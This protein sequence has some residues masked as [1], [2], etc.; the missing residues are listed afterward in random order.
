MSRTFP[1]VPALMILAAC[2]NGDM[3]DLEGYVREIKARAP[4]PLEPLPEIAPIASLPFP[5]QSRRDPFVPD[6]QS[7][8]PAP[9]PAGD[10]R[11]PDPLRHKET[12]ERF[13]LDALTMVGTLAQGGR[14]RALIATADRTLFQV[15]VGDYLGTHNGRITHI[16]E[17]RIEL[18]E[19][20]PAG[21]AWRERRATLALSR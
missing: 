20:V 18:I 16:T 4:G 14:I 13:P 9:A 3:T 11:V 21:G 2:G 5:P 6:H 10:D 12:L 8:I 19:I 17:D 15:G 1:A 7:T